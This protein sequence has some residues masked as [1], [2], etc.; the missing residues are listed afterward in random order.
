MNAQQSFGRPCHTTANI[1]G[2]LLLICF[3][4]ILRKLLL[5]EVEFTRATTTRLPPK[6]R[7]K[8]L[9]NGR[10]LPVNQ[11]QN[12]N[13]ACAAFSTSGKQQPMT[14][15]IR[16]CRSI[17]FARDLNTGSG[18]L[19]EVNKIAALIGWSLCLCHL[20][21]YEHAA[22]AHSGTVPLD[23]RKLTPI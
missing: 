18:N 23:W 8:W 12:A 16:N 3:T 6:N 19:T 11:R 7:S 15:Q 10:Q 5:A 14:T 2:C 17:K 9:S 4:F 22:S 21:K 20:K 13:P 1:K